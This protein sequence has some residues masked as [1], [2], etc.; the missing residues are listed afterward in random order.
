MDE[1][2]VYDE[3]RP[4][5]RWPWILAILA[6]LFAVK[7]VG[8]V[9][10]HPELFEKKE[11]T[12]EAKTI[13]DSDPYLDELDNQFIREGKPYRAVGMWFVERS[14]SLTFLG[15][16]IDP[17]TGNG[18]AQ[19]QITKRYQ[20][21]PETSFRVGV[22]QVPSMKGD[23]RRWQSIGVEPEREFA[24]ISDGRLKL[25]RDGVMIGIAEVDRVRKEFGK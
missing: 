17:R 10:R 11:A 13:S 22:R 21:D 18:Y 16:I 5:R 8:N 24:L 25:I 4:R 3:P 14:D 9:I 19:I 12:A 23:V 20:D 2:V 1:S 6:G 7:F 15:L